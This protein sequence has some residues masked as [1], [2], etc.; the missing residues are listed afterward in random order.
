MRSGVAAFNGVLVGIGLTAISPM[1]IHDEHLQP[2]VLAFV[3]VG[4]FVRLVQLGVLFGHPNWRHALY[5][6]N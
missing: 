1:L 6:N 4:S 5:N 2:V 3:C